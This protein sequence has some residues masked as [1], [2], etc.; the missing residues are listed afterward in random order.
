MSHHET[1]PEAEAAAPVETSGGGFAA[2]QPGLRMDPS[3]WHG[4]QNMA[5]RSGLRRSSR[6]VA[7]GMGTVEQEVSQLLQDTM[8]PVA[9]K[10]VT[11]W[12]R[13]AAAGGDVA[14]AIGL[15]FSLLA[16]SRLT[17]QLRSALNQIWNAEPPSSDGAISA[18]K[19]FFR[20]RAFALLLVVASGPW[21][22][23]VVVSRTLLTA[24]HH[25]FSARVVPIET[26]ETQKAA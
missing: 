24:F 13:E 15:G 26:I 17:T 9:A 11:S 1:L 4:R 14:S 16:A 20:K 12:V 10:A 25:Y 19:D 7:L 21:L 22:L 23:L 5:R 18:V 6:R 3:T 8:G 2:P